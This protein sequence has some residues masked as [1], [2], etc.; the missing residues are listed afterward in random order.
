MRGEKILVVEDEKSIASLI[1]QYL[2]MKG[3]DVVVAD[4]GD[5]ALS[6]CYETLP[7][8]VILDLM[9]PT[10]DGWEVCRRLKKDPTTM[11]IPIIMLTARRDERDVI[12]GLELG[13]DDY[14]KKPFSLSELH[15]RIK[16]ILRRSSSALRSNESIKMDKLELN[17]DTG[18]LTYKDK[19]IILTPI[20]TEIFKVLIKNAPKVV[21]KEQLLAKVWGT[22]LGETRTIDAHICRLRAKI[23]ELGMDPS[24]IMTIRHR[25][26]KIAV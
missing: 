9:L 16:S 18:E 11:D 22:S 13:A 25:G 26:Y 20:E 23:K 3:Y 17:T 21:S 4:D 12:E 24:L 6:I 8:L 5:K 1:E 15:A 19:R 7:Q 14:I 2:A 10:M